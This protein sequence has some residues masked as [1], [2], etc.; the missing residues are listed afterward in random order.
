MREN[1]QQYQHDGSSTMFL[2]QERTVLRQQR[3]NEGPGTLD[4]GRLASGGPGGKIEV[5]IARWPSPLPV[6]R[7]FVCE[8]LGRFRRVSAVAIARLNFLYS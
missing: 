1:A 3:A 6:S 4:P 7:F 5:A 2:H 8:D